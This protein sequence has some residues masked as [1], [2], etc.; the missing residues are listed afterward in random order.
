MIFTKKGE[1]NFE[2]KLKEKTKKKKKKLINKK[3]KA[4]T[5]RNTKSLHNNNPIGKGS[6]PNQGQQD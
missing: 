4:S 1:L 5:S 6:G 2:S 3:R